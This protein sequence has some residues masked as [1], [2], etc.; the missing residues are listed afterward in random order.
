[1]TYEGNKDASTIGTS[2][3]QASRLLLYAWKHTSWQWV[4]YFQG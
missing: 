2:V 1:M 4:S 3:S